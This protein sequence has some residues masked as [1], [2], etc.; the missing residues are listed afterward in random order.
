MD[1]LSKRKA[2]RLLGINRYVKEFHKK[3]ERIYREKADKLQRDRINALKNNDVAGYLRMVQVC[4]SLT[5]DPVIEFGCF[6]VFTDVGSHPLHL[7]C[8]PYLH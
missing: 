1:D 4:T 7:H 2:H 8:G 3:K 5:N 6:K